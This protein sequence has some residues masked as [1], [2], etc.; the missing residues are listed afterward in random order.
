MTIPD[1][2]FLVFQCIVPQC[3]ASIATVS[4]EST[5]GVLGA[6]LWLF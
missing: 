2:T 4:A 5:I 6:H 1:T 3:M